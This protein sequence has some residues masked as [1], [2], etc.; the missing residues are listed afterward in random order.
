MDAIHYKLLCINVN[1][2]DQI[3]EEIRNGRLNT[4]LR[5]INELGFNQQSILKIFILAGDTKHLYVVSYTTP[6]QKVFHMNAMYDDQDLGY[7][8]AATGLLQEVLMVASVTIK[9][10]FP[11][12]K[13]NEVHRETCEY[14]WY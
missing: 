1:D 4:S 6:L 11:T 9:K 2:I 13:K 12:K 10:I 5:N 7:S 3:I 8:N 14:N